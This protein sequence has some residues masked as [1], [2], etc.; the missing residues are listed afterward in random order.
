MFMRFQ[1]L[2]DTVLKNTFWPENVKTRPFRGNGSSWLDKDLEVVED[3]LNDDRHQDEYR[4]QN[5]FNCIL[6]DYVSLKGIYR[7]IIKHNK[8][9]ISLY[10]Y[11]FHNKVIYTIS[12]YI[13]VSFTECDHHNR[14][15]G[16][17]S[18]HN[19]GNS[20]SIIYKLEIFHTYTE[21]IIN[22]N[23]MGGTWKPFKMH[24]SIHRE[25]RLFKST[26]CNI[27]IRSLIITVHL[28]GKS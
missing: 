17:M 26:K 13:D 22:Q 16:Y 2:T 10:L 1:D 6:E 24:M 23:S 4:S 3:V 8:I 19:R 18:H 14:R 20:I 27:L 28:S 12:I 15:K 7:Y 5:L 9:T 25:E 21:D 11:N